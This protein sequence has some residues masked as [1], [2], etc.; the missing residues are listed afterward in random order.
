MDGISAAANIIAL[1][2]AL[3]DMVELEEKVRESFGKVIYSPRIVNQLS[4]I[5]RTFSGEE[6][7]RFSPFS[8]CWALKNGGCFANIG[9]T[10]ESDLQPPI[11]R[12]ASSTALSV[13][14]SSYFNRCWCDA[15]MSSYSDLEEIYIRCKKIW[16][17]RSGLGGKIQHLNAWR[18]A[19]KT[20]EEIKRLESKVEWCYKRFMVRNISLFLLSLREVLRIGW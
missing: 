8:F 5:F 9:K 2:T 13:K 10:A 20:E 18:K 4:N 7:Q 12:R 19:S 17:R 11:V 16:T 6:K 14:N 3:K 15:D 1:A